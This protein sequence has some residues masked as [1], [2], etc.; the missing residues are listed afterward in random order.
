MHWYQYARSNRKC[1]THPTKESH[2]PYSPSPNPKK[3]IPSSVMV[4]TYAKKNFTQEKRRRTYFA[5]YVAKD[6]AT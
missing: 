3:P 2:T 5:A 6:G 1:N 4:S